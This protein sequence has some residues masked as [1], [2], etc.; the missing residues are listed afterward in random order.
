MASGLNEYGYK[1]V[2]CFS[3]GKNNFESVASKRIAKQL[4]YDWKFINI[5]HNKAKNFYLSKNYNEY[6]K[7]T[8]DGCVTL[9]Y[10]VCMLYKLLESGYISKKDIIINGNSGIL[11][12][13]DIYLK[14]SFFK[15][16]IIKSN[17]ILSEALFNKHF[18]KVLQ[19]GN[20]LAI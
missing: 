10:K 8:N 11:F 19:L 7:Y 12:L 3:Y 17:N 14:I 16:F 4:D 5:T 6:I 9:Q 2:K 20:L 18:E 15:K 13:E 1:K